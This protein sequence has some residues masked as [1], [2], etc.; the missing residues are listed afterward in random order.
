MDYNLFIEWAEKNSWYVTK[1][2]KTAIDLN[3]SVKLKYKFLPLEY[4]NFITNL[5]EVVSPK[6]TTWFLCECDYNNNSKSQYK[7]NEFELLELNASI[8][9]AEWTK[10]IKEWWSQYFP[11]MISVDG[12]YSFW[13]INIFDGIVVRGA[14]PEFEEVEKV[15]NNF[16][17]FLLLIMEKKICIN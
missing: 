4:L 16:D 17:E 6:D 5:E 11:I 10:R 2:K 3:D 1:R 7:W 8:D 9:D 14:E 13:A 15:A 12:C